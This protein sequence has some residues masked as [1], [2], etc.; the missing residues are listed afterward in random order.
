MNFDVDGSLN[1]PHRGYVSLRPKLLLDSRSLQSVQ[2]QKRKKFSWDSVSPCQAACLL[3]FAHPHRTRVVLA[4]G[5]IAIRSFAAV[6]LGDTVASNPRRDSAN[7]HRNVVTLPMT[8][9]SQHIAGGNRQCFRN[10]W[11]TST[12]FD[13]A[14]ARPFPY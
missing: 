8:I 9:L 3:P 1:N 4:V 10:L 2:R 11:R 7:M 5:N 13:S 14:A 6:I 12:L